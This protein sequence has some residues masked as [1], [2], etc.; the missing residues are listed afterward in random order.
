M[1][2]VYTREAI[3]TCFN[4]KRGVTKITAFVLTNKCFNHL[5]MRN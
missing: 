3:V 5:L 1:L 4:T 2:R